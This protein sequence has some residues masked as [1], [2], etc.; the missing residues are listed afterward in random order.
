MQQLDANGV[1]KS[2]ATNFTYV[3][4]QGWGSYQP[5]TERLPPGVNVTVGYYLQSWRYF[6]HVEHELRRD[7]TFKVWHAPGPQLSDQLSLNVQKL[8]QS[9]H[10]Q[11]LTHIFLLHQTVIRFGKVATGSSQFGAKNCDGEKSCVA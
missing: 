4:E 9:L 7:L 2:N 5:L 3:G 6:A 11:K 10:V 8:T 1:I